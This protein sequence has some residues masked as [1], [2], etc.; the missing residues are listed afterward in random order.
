M[1]ITIFLEN[2][3]LGLLEMWG[4]IS[5]EK[6]RLKQLIFYYK[7]RELMIFVGTVQKRT[8]LKI[9]KWNFGRISKTNLFL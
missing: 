7:I 9:Y 8:T 5:L 6:H 3:N 4:I 2:L 1:E